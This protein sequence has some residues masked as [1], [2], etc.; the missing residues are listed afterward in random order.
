M[1]GELK[2][3][4]LF[5]ILA[6]IFTVSFSVTSLSYDFDLMPESRKS[7]PF[8][9]G[10]IPDQRGRRTAVFL[11]MFF[12]SS[13]H[14]AI[15]MIGIALLALINPVTLAVVL[16]ADYS[17]FFLVK[18]L[19]SDLSYW[20][21]IQGKIYWLLVVVE[22]LVVKTLVD[23]TAI[24]QLRHSC[25]MGGLQWFFSLLVGHLTSVVVVRYF[26]DWRVC[27]T[28]SL[29]SS[30]E[31]FEAY[32]HTSSVG[33]WT[34]LVTLEVC[35]VAT[36]V[37][38]LLIIKRQYIVT[39]FST[40]TSQEFSCRIFRESTDDEVRVSQVLLHPFQIEPIKEDLKQYCKE[41]WHKWAHEDKPEWFLRLKHEIP[42]EYVPA[43]LVSQKT[44]VQLTAFNRRGSGAVLLDTMKKALV[45]NSG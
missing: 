17:I 5:S 40:E 16:G 42:A 23:F 2:V 28:S 14:I 38:F 12:F 43:S 9:Y 7:A 30:S 6:S 26:L 39:F 44:M 13:F 34:A 22:R 29:T 33:L 37:T 18:V 11:L 8:F 36:F 1:N 20:I 25:E 24:T 31:P 32:C 3:A 21:N 45:T 35:F 27:E 19:R 4:I 41:N 15:R 10:C